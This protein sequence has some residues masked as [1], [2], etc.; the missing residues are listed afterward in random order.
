MSNKYHDIAIAL[1]GVCQSAMMVS[2]LANT[3]QCNTSIYDVSLKSIFNT[4]PL[5]T[6]DVFGGI[7]NV[8]SGLEF[9]TKLFNQNQQEKVEIM[10]YVFGAI[11]ITTKLIKND[12]ALSKISQRLIK[13]KS[14]YHQENDGEFIENHRDEITYSLA[15]IYSDVI[16]PLTTKIRVNGKVEYL[17]NAFIQAKVR[18]ALFASIRASILWYQVGGNRLQLLLMRNN[19]TNAAKEILEQNYS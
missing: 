11:G 2:K 12:D 13:I 6:S 14:L 1:G 8:R 10:R 19:I 3:G 9:L 17:Q 4:D 5:S 16:S 15:G 18:T 7:N